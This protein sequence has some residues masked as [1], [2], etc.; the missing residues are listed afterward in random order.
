MAQE[1]RNETLEN[2]IFKQYLINEFA[3]EEDKLKLKATENNKKAIVH[4]LSTNDINEFKGYSRIVENFKYFQ[5]QIN[6]ENFEIIHKGLSK[7]MFVD[8]GLDRQNDNP[9]RIFESLNS[10][11]L[12]LSQADL[13]RNYILMDLTPKVQSKIYN[14]YWQFIE[15]LAKDEENNQNKLSDFVRDFLTL[16]NRNIPNKDKVYLEFKKKY[17][18]EKTEQELEEIL[19][20]IKSLVNFYNKLLN[21]KNEPDK[22]IRIQLEYIKKLEI[23]VAYPFLMK[24][25]EDFANKIIDK[26]IFIQVL[27][28]IQSYTWRRFI[29]G[30]PTS[31][32]NKIFM[33][34]Y[35][36]VDTQNYLYSIQK[37]LLQK[38][39]SQRFPRDEET[40][41]AF[42]EKDIYNIKSKNRT[43]LF[44][45]LENFENKEPV[46][47]ENITIEHIFPQKPDPQWKSDLNLD[48]YNFIKNN[49]LN[50]IGNLTL[51]GNN[52]KL[53]NKSFLEKKSMN[54][55][56]KEQ[57][58]IF[59]RLWLNRVLKQIEKWDKAE[60]EKRANIIS[61]RFL[62]IWK[63]PEININI[64][65]EEI[66]DEINI[67]EIEDPT[68][69]QIEYA[70]F[71]GEKIEPRD[72]ADFYTTIMKKL[73]ELQPEAF[74]DTNLGKKLKISMN[75]FEYKNLQK[76]KLS[77]AYFILTNTSS[78]DKFNRIRDT[79]AIL[80]IED[81]LFIKYKN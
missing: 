15:D 69:K 53:S 16:E 49:Y 11:G 74:I 70:I 39:G 68:G 1:L 43:Y 8:I 55:D 47:T 6:A 17:S 78:L 44:E 18:E 72:I 36:E 35:K 9:Q 64:E 73:F 67:F 24:V 40:I 76:Q 27:E 66:N 22:E 14:N 29:L 42:K 80:D 2:K 48:E 77:D 45:R 5:T 28:L 25:Y 12:A 3:K 19:I 31:S 13:I 62:K 52:G 59:S 79:L 41:K 54:V 57:G 58:Y 37:S 56:A 75:K 71:K 33:S 21:P 23:N 61:E 60:I 4:I 32:L 63:F 38:S 30:L 81:E 20:K 50:T 26:N 34:F 46:I 10:T 51:S 7:L 65:I